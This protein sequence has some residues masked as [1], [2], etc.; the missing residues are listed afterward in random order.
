[1]SEGKSED[2]TVKIPKAMA[3]HIK[4]Q[5]Y[6]KWFRDLDDF[7]VCAVREKMEDGF[8]KRQ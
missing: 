6:F 8:S 3:D 1:M 2:V 7:V 4:Q 5:L